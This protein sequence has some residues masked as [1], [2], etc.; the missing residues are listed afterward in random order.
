MQLITRCPQCETAFAFETA[1]LRLAQGWVRCGKCA[2]LFE[3]DKHLF[4]RDG[5]HALDRGGFKGRGHA[6]TGNSNKQQQGAGAS[7]GERA[8][9]LQSTAKPKMTTK[10]EELH[11]D[12]KA[13]HDTLDDE[14]GESGESGEYADT[15]SSPD[16][17]HFD[18]TFGLQKMK[19]LS[20]E[21]QEFSGL[22]SFESLRAKQAAPSLQSEQPRIDGSSG[23][24]EVRQSTAQTGER[25]L[26]A[27]QGRKTSWTLALSVSFLMLIAVGQIVWA[28]KEVIGALSAQSH[29][30]LQSVCNE[31]G[32]ELGW[33]MEP[34]SLK[35]ESS[36]FKL[37]TGETYKVKLR[38]KNHQDYA[39]KT[40][41]L[42]LAL[43]GGDEGVLV[44]K[45]FSTK[46][47]ELQ[48]AIAPDKDL[49]I[50]FN[51]KVDEQI[52]P[53]IVGYHLDFFYP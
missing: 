17:R 3:A 20:L 49:I 34:Q 7:E 32:T 1:Q 33:P 19:S 45:V 5:E 27:G 9:A 18:L 44:R 28:N 4:E 2:M 13:L 30:F 14:S 52:A 15:S 41:W 12:L 21:M 36:S 8:R 31:L 26:G 23:V 40:P 42:E 29:L 11:S 37:L 38:L 53:H 24:A 22:Q 10:I 16:R 50:S 48:Q 43:L 39:V 51:I 35:I 6:V 47:L 25:S 46:E